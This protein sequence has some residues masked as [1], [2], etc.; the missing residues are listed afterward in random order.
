MFSGFSWF[1]GSG[2]RGTYISYE[3]LGTGDQL[4]SVS[5]EVSSSLNPVAY[6]KFAPS[7]AP[8]GPTTTPLPTVTPTPTWSGTTTTLSSTFIDCQPNPSVWQFRLRTQGALPGGA[9][10]PTTV[11]LT[12]ASGATGTAIKINETIGENAAQLEYR[13]FDNLTDA[14]VSGTLLLPTG[15]TGV[16]ELMFAPDCL[17]GTP[18]TATSN[19]NETVCPP[20][21]QLRRALRPMHRRNSHRLLYGN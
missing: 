14:L 15:L 8:A 1:E 7:C 9:N 16:L 5:G 4:V 21:P 11:Q 19:P 3:H 17:P 6:L 2:Y 10:W 20:T 13:S 18:A 12:F